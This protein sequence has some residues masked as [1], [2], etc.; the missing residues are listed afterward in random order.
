[1]TCPK[2]GRVLSLEEAFEDK[3]IDLPE[4]IEKTLTAEEARTQNR[5]CPDCGRTTENEVARAS[6]DWCKTCASGRIDI[7]T[8]ENTGDA[9]WAVG[10]RADVPPWS[11]QTGEAFLPKQTAAEKVAKEYQYGSFLGMHELASCLAAEL[12]EVRKVC[13]D[14]YPDSQLLA[15]IHQLRKQ[16]KD[17]PLKIKAF[18]WLAS[19]TLTIQRFDD[20]RGFNHEPGQDLLENI[21]N[22]QKKQL[23]DNK[24]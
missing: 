8:R 13:G 14:R 24:S 4:E 3:H 16:L 22:A 21:Q 17:L 20:D 23:H 18:D 2:H 12:D 11:N 10:R 6:E 15:T 1:M 9:K 7:K 5:P 19:S